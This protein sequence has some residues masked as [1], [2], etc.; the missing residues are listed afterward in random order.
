MLDSLTPGGVPL[1]WPRRKGLSLPVV[2]TGSLLEH[3]VF[4]PALA[5]VLVAL[6]VRF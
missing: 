1:F 3:V 5:V 4:L 6:L 2:R